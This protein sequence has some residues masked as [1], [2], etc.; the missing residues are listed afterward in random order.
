MHFFILFFI[1][2]SSFKVK[3]GIHGDTHLSICISGLLLTLLIGN[4]SLKTV[5]FLGLNLLKPDFL[6]L[7]HLLSSSG[8][9][10]NS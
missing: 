5:I 3:C 10:N 8:Y 6:I 1:F 7:N 2:S 9:L 4:C